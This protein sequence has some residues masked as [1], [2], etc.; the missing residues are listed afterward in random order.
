MA[1]PSQ[2]SAIFVHALPRKSL[3]PKSSVEFSEYQ[4]DPLPPSLVTAR[5]TMCPHAVEMEKLIHQHVLLNAQVFMKLS[6]NLDRA[7]VKIRVR[8]TIALKEL[9]VFQVEMFVFLICT[10][11]VLNIDVVSFFIVKISNLLIFKN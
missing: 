9:P 5:L 4:I 1:L 6:M 8:D 11:R 2:L 7:R 3:A 10:I